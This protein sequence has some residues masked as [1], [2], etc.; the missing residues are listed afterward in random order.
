MSIF[1]SVLCKH[2]VCPVELAE[3][4]RVMAASSAVLSLSVLQS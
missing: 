3:S 1:F 2:G 4:G